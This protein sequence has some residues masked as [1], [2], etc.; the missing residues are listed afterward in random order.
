MLRDGVGAG[1]E[2]RI[3]HGDFDVVFLA[4]PCASYS[5]SHRPQ[6]RKRK[7]PNG[8]KDIP[9]EWRNYLIKH[10]LLG[11]LSA[12]LIIAAH[13][14][15]VAWALENPAD[16]G[17]RTS[18]AWWHK[19]SDHAPIFLTKAIAEA[20]RTTTASSRTFAQ[21]AFEAKVQKWT[22][23]IHSS[24]LDEELGD[25]DSHICRHGTEHHEKTAHGRD[26]D[27]SSNSAAAATY[28][29]EMNEFIADALARWARR[30]A[31]ARHASQATSDG[32]L[33][34]DGAQLGVE[35]R[36]ACDRARR[37][38]P[39]FASMRN[40]RPSSSHHLRREALPSDLLAPPPHQP[41]SDT[42]SSRA[43]GPP[44]PPL[45]PSAAH[46]RIAA[47][48]IH[49]YELFLDGVYELEVSSWLRL[50]DLA[51]AD[52][53]AGRTARAVPSRTIGQDKLQPWAR[54]IV[55][56]TQDPHN[57]KLVVASTRHTTF[58]G[59]RQI[60]MAAIRRV[61]ADL[62][63]HDTDIVDQVGEGGV[64][65]RSDCSMDIVLAFHHLGLRERGNAKHAAKVIEA[66]FKEGWADRPVRHLPFV[67]CRVLP[68]NVIFQERSRLV[69]S[70]GQEPPSLEAYLK[71]R[72]TTDASHGGDA[73]IN[74]GVSI[75]D[76][77]VLLPT[78]Q[79]HGRGLA[80]ADTAGGEG[81]QACSY[82]VD[83]E[84]AYRFCP[85]QEADLWMQVFVWWD[86]DGVAGWCIDRRL[87]FGGA[88][89]PNRFERISTLVA[90]HIQSKHAA[91]D[92]DHPLPHRARLWTAVR[93]SLQDD[94][95]LPSGECQ[96]HPR[97]LQVYIDDFIGAALDDIVEG[98]AD[99][100][101]DIVIPPEQ[102]ESEGGS[103]AAPNSRVY[104]HA[105]LAVQGL[106]DVGLSA[107]PGKVIVGDPITGLGLRISRLARRIDCPSLKRASMLADITRQLEAA[108]ARLEAGRRLSET[109]VG[110]LCNLSQVFPELK[111]A[112][113]GGYAVT[114][115]SWLIKGRR[116]QP[117]D[118]SFKEGSVAHTEWIELL[119]M[120]LH[121]IDANEGVDIAPELDFPALSSPGMI[122]ITT[123]AS[124]ND[125]VGGYAF[126][127]EDPFTVYIMS[128]PWD[129]YT[130]AALANGAAEESAKDRLAPSLSVSAVELFGATAMA[131]AVAS[132]L[133]SPIG[134]IIDSIT[135]VGDSDSA[136]GVLNAA[137]TG[138]RQM[139]TILHLGPAPLWLGVSVARE[140][141]TDA[142]RLSHPAMY[143][144]VEAD[145]VA[146]GLTVVRVHISPA[147]WAALR[148]AAAIGTAPRRQPRR[149]R[150]TPSSS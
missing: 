52:I 40:R 101:A 120:A 140:L 130:L 124:G 19:H 116:L 108:V 63:W 20:I 150:P 33:V 115:S 102:I 44:S 131:D 22:T 37:R 123:D 77:R 128:D 54:G 110:R 94:G 113:H 13:R 76:R 43:E 137:T 78:V 100:D 92:R 4:T 1:L 9:L 97:H 51:A 39:R 79:Q 132:H 82:V 45:D 90:A 26:L 104:A 147:S 125:G 10:N 134:D 14:A 65:V 111:A 106:R 138:N 55:W 7:Q 73:S 135:A 24:N 66:D 70:A 98:R 30:A 81:V 83:A 8:V 12:R 107:A 56:D 59:E 75:D 93:R 148:D 146:A 23:I 109:L 121:L 34:S 71:P 72:V 31:H 50:A 28:P 61:A 42:S 5:I 15:G 57:C 47:G 69:P 136:A 36:E 3:F 6:L 74:A 41:P 16:R 35:V 89:A 129:D 80:I 112:L 87:C 49:I 142:D 17:D 105:Q 114:S 133:G 62:A 149:K 144:L 143:E 86:A 141:N 60:D 84:S 122:T 64:Q 103:P 127:A 96:L 38:A 53:I 67:P 118:I 46:R 95:L 25:L 58:K 32:G 21:C 117:D 27:G 2:T 88:F 139:R 145:A 18:K 126:R 11:E 91:Y 99:V 29:D 119:E 68:R 85:V 48:P